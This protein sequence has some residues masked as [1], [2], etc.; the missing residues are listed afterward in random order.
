M[1]AP[2]Q[3]KE[4]EEALAECV[5]EVCRCCFA[6]STAP[7]RGAAA[8]AFR[9]V[10]TK[11]GCTLFDAPCWTDAMAA[12][13]REQFPCVQMACRQSSASLG[14]FCVAMVL[15]RRRKGGENHASREAMLV[16]A[17]VMGALLLLAATAWYHLMEDP[18]QEAGAAS[19]SFVQRLQRMASRH[20]EL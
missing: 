20:M 10:A 5:R 11:E 16:A 6:S 17:A 4:E 7:G 13:V 12:C 2:K 9:V 3:E 1:H 19:E 15:P 18:R 14:G 8:A